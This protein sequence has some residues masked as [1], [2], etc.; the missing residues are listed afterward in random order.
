MSY[1]EVIYSRMSTES[2]TSDASW[3]TEMSYMFMYG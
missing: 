3:W 2:P 1:S